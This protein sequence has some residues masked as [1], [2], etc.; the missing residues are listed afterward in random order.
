MY[1]VDQCRVCGTPIVIR[2][3]TSQA[4]QELAIRKPVV[5]EKVWRARGYLTPPTPLQWRANPAD[6]CCGLCGRKLLQRKYR[7]TI[8]FWLVLL[9]IV[10]VT[11]II[12]GVV[13]FLP[14]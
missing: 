9:V 2:S 3:P 5:P 14:H 13:K 6:G 1:G 7:T 12:V 4:D 10:I 11:I 8:R